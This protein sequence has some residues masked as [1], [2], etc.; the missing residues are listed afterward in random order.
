[1]AVSVF[2]DTSKEP[3]SIQLDEALGDT[4]M[5]SDLPEETISAIESAREYTE[6]R[7]IRFDVSATDDIAVV[8]QLATIKMSG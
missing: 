8:K 1:M 3:T 5:Q 4:A 6:G 2:D 7:S